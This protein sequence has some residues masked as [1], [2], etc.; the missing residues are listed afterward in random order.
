MLTLA[1]VRRLGDALPQAC[2]PLVEIVLDASACDGRLAAVC[3]STRTPHFFIVDPSQEFLRRVV[4]HWVLAWRAHPIRF[5]GT[6]PRHGHGD[7]DIASITVQPGAARR[8]R[9]E[10]RT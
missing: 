8:R 3:G 2:S 10:A 1:R 5:D 4:G 9:S 6:G 7:F